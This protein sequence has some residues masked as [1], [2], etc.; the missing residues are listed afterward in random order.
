MSDDTI[1]PETT[2]L[3]DILNKPRKDFTKD[4]IVKIVD[5]LGICM[6]NFR[7]VGGDGRLKTLNFVIQG[8]KHLDR[9]LTLGE[10]VDGSSLFKFVDAGMSDLYVVPRY[11][12]AFV[13]PFSK[14]P[15]LDLLCSYFSPD[16]SP[17][18]PAPEYVLKKADERLKEK[19][20]MALE[21]LGELEFY[22]I[23]PKSNLYPEEVQRGYHTS[24]PFSKF[25]GL[26]KE[27]ML[28]ISM[29]GGRIKYGHSE[30][31]FVRYGDLEFEQ[32][33]IE[34]LPMSLEEAADYIVLARW[35]L[36][37]I[38]HRYGVNITFAPKV[39][40]GHAGSGLHIHSRLVKDGVNMIVGHKGLSKI[41]LKLIGGY[42]KLAPSLTA[43]GNTIPISYLRLVP[44]Q[45][46]PTAICW[47]YRNRSALVRVPLAWDT[48]SAMH[49]IANPNEKST[50][51]LEIHPQTVEFRAPDG[52][53]NV[54]LLLAGM[55]VAALNGLTSS[56]SLELA[57]KLF[58]DSNIFRDPE[59]YKD[60]PSL[61]SSCW[62]SAEK[63]QEQRK[64]YE[65]GGVFPPEL[66]DWTISKLKGYEDIDL[67]ERL[68]RKDREIEKLVMQFLHHP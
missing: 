43:F 20:G 5:K 50:Y 15:T 59:T 44:H 35:M 56:D 33:E 10:R 40:V 30:V 62:E 22:I 13:N 60:L 3:E 31:G 68:Y 58:V 18:D 32:N 24:Y 37:A 66:I 55:A 64:F 23:A 65:E 8:K 45:E 48:T 34:F 1:N 52:S 9:I 36:R 25:E 67:S 61:P 17:F 54:H 41:G 7:Y 47:G 63:L 29:A 57:E 28:A 16:G 2:N 51:Q 14:I 12:T 46:A 42:L 21:A 6:L 27:A 4:D 49:R 39:L 53:A 38:G 19:T 26:R 11:R